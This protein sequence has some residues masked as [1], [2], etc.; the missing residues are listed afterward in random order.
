MSAHAHTDFIVME[1]WIQ[2]RMQ[3]S[4]RNC[5]RSKYEMTENSRI[6]LELILDF[7]ILAAVTMK[8]SLQHEYRF[9]L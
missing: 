9:H 3:A 2:N 4:H 7:A 5:Q 8:S 1:L 6:M